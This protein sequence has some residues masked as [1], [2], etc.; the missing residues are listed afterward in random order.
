MNYRVEKNIAKAQGRYPNFK[1]WEEYENMEG[2][3]IAH[4]YHPTDK[5]YENDGGPSMSLPDGFEFYVGETDPDEDMVK[6]VMLMIP[7]DRFDGRPVATGDVSVEFDVPLDAVAYY[8]ALHADD[9][10]AAC[11]IVQ[12]R[13]DVKDGLL[14]SIYFTGDPEMAWPSLNVLARHKLLAPYWA[15]QK[16][17]IADSEVAS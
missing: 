11:L 9:V 17:E 5:S 15:A 7:N 13:L 6:G 16:S 8:E 12:D 1:S 3:L 10:D 14:A 2:A 4:G